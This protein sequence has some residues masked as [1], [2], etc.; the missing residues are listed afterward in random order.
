MTPIRPAGARDS[1][2]CCDAD[3]DQVPYTRS[4]VGDGTPAL[5]DVIGVDERVAEARRATHVRS[6]DGN[7]AGGEL[8]EERIEDGTF[9]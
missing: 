8:L 9:L 1:P 4:H 7:P 6:K 5:F 3:V 2:G